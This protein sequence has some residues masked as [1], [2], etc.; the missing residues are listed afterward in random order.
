MSFLGYI[1]KL[2]REATNLLILRG[3]LPI[4]T[5]RFF[6]LSFELANPP[7]QK[8]WVDADRSRDLSCSRGTVDGATYRLDDEFA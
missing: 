8:T 1:G 5:K 6:L 2:S 3:E 4:A 7:I